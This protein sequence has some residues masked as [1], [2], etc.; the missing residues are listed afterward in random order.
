LTTLIKIAFGAAML[1]A[2]LLAVVSP[3]T[4]VK[5]NGKAQARA[6]A[7]EQAQKQRAEKRKQLL[8]VYDEM[9]LRYDVLAERV[10]L[11]RVNRQPAAQKRQPQL[12]RKPRLRL[13]KP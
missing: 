3:F 9:L 6:K 12:A 10:A 11:T 7:R 2:G 1:G 5:R 8:K 4:R 13:R